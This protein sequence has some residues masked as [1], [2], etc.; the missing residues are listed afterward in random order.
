MTDEMRYT[1]TDNSSYPKGGVSCS[2]DSFVVNQTLVFQ[3]KFCGKSPALRVAA[4][5]YKQINK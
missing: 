4:K 2:I 5:R 3:I 1:A